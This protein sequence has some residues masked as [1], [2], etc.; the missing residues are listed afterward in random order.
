MAGRKLYR[1]MQGRM[2]DIDKLRSSNEDVRAVGNMNVNARGDILGLSGKVFK[3]KE[4]V[5]KEY[6]ESPKGKASDSKIKTESPAENV[7]K[8]QPEIKK[9]NP[10]EIAQTYPKTQIVDTF[11]NKKSDSK[12][13]DSKSGID[14]ALDG[15]E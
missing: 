12:S 6:Y 8:M 10:K 13:A 15:L 1:T 3:T 7:K 9:T 14:A 5:M 4:Q 11:K 2:V